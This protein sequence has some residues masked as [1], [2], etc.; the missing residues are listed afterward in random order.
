MS[1]PINLA[2]PHIA[3]NV[4]VIFSGLALLNQSN[5][6]YP[7]KNFNTLPNILPIQSKTFI[8]GPLIAANF[9]LPSFFTSGSSNPFSA[10]FS[11]SF[12]P[13]AWNFFLSPASISLN[14]FFFSAFSSLSAL[15]SFL[16]FLLNHSLSNLISSLIWW[17]FPAIDDV[18]SP[19]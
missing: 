11:F 9:L 6:L 15:K 7:I 14:P 3:L 18:V 13:N 8:N 12:L 2:I 5:A 16:P 10:A 1:L 4:F 19:M 17:K